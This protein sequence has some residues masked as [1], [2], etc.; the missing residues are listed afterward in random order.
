MNWEAAGAIAEIVASIGVILSLIYLALQIRSQNTESRIAS[1]NELVSQF[2]AA[3]RYLAR[4]K[5]LA[6]LMLNGF[7]DFEALRDAERLRLSTHM[8]GLA[9]SSEAMHK[10]RQGGLLAESTNNRG[11]MSPA[12]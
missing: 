5:E 11:W 8:T 4:A 9:R 1:A 2:L 12:D 6:E 3:N 10:H 7:R